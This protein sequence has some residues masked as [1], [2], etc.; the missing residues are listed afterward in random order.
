LKTPIFISA[1]LLNVLV[2]VAQKTDSLIVNYYA[3]SPFAENVNGEVVGVE[4]EIVQEYVAWLKTKKSI[5]TI[6]RYNKFTDFDKFYSTTKSASK[7]TIG[8][9]SVTVNSERAK[10]VDFTS[11]YLKNVSFCVTNGNALDIKTKTRDEIVRVLGSMTALTLTNTTL[12]KY[13]NDIKK[14]YINDLKIINQES[15]KKILD[16]IARKVL[17]F[18]YVDAVGFWFYIKNNP[19]K[20]LKT[21]KVLSQSNEVFAFMLP[22]GSP[23]KVMFGEFFE[24]PNGF[25]NSKTYRDILEKYL[26]PYMTQ[27]LAIN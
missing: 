8:L 11:A 24:G 14:S 18:G 1:L 13:V 12:N 25:K 6:V 10:E 2:C 16:E 7:N 15:E 3:Q 22:K 9:G 20:F 5:T 21:Q 17:F 26:G 27:T 19:Q 4:T 23:H